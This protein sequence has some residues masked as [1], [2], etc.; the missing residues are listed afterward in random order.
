MQVMQ[1]NLRET[2]STALDAFGMVRQ[3]MTSRP[4]CGSPQQKLFRID[5]FVVHLIAAFS[6][7]STPLQAQNSVKAGRFHVEHPTLVNLGFEWA[8]EGD[9]N[10]DATVAVQFRP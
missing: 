6:L 10:R 4:N 7:C 2:G 5:R 8:I 9:V 1:A 3:T